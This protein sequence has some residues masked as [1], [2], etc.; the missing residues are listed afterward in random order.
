MTLLVWCPRL[1]RRGEG[2]LTSFY[3]RGDVRLAQAKALT[4]QRPLVGREGEA[5]RDCKRCAVDGSSGL[6]SRQK[7]EAGV[8]EKQWAVGFIFGLVERLVFV[9]DAGEVIRVPCCGG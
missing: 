7:G 9:E 1:M 6:S 5:V 4:S 8:R 3:M 2:K